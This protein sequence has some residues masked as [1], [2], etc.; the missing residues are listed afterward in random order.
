MQT[1]CQRKTQ[2]GKARILLMILFF[3]G[4]L[5]G[6][7]ADSLSVSSGTVTINT[8]T[9][10]DFITQ[11]GGTLTGAG[12]LGS[13]GLWTWSAG[14]LT[15]V[16]G[17][18]TA[19]AM[20]GLTISGTSTKYLTNRT[21]VNTSGN[22]A[23]WSGGTV[24]LYNTSTVQN[25]GTF[26]VTADLTMSEQSGTATF[27]NQGTFIKSTTT[28]TTS[29][30]GIDFINATNAQLDVQK[31][32]LSITGA[33]TNE[34][35]ISVASGSALT[36]GGSSQH[37][38]GGNI[39]VAG[40]L[41]LSS[42]AGNTISGTYQSSNTTI[43]A[44]TT[45]FNSFGA[46]LG[47]TS[48]TGSSTKVYFNENNV[49]TGNITLNS[50]AEA[51]FTKESGMVT[52]GTLNIYNS[53]KANMINQTVEATQIN[54]QSSGQL[55]TSGTQL[56]NSSMA[57]SVA[58]GIAN[59][60]NAT[61]VT[62]N[63][64]TASSGTLT[65]NNS[66]LNSTT[67]TN[68]GA[69]MTFQSG[70]IVS[71][72]NFS[73]TSGA[74]TFQAGSSLNSTNT[75]L[76]GGTVTLETG[77]SIGSTNFTVSGATVSF[78][79]TGP[80]SLT[81]FTQSSGTVNGS[82]NIEVN[83]VYTWSGGNLYGVD[84]SQTLTAKG[85]MNL[86]TTTKYL[87]NRAIV[88]TA[89]Q[90]ATWNAGTINMYNTS[91]FVN[92]GL[93]EITGN[94]SMTE[95]SGTATFENYGTLTKKTGTSTTT[96][97]SVDFLNAEN[98]TMNIETGAMTISGLLTN[99]GTVNI[100]SGRTLTLSGS[101]QHQI[102][103]TVQGAGI[104]TLSSS[105]GNTISGMY[106]VGTTNI[107]GGSTTS[108]NSAN[109]S[110]GTASI[111]GSNTKVNFNSSNVQTNNMTVNSS[112]EAYFLADQGTVNI[113]GTLLVANSAKTSMTNQ[114]VTANQMDVQSSGQLIAN[115]TQL[116]S[117]SMVFNIAGGIADISNATNVNANTTTAS[118]GTLTVNNST[119][120]SATFTNSG[121]T[122]TFQT[123]A[124][125]N[126]NS[127]SSTGGTTTFQA[128]SF[129]NS[130]SATVS[131]GTTILEAGS[132]IN[133]TNFTVTGNGT[134]NGTAS[135]TGTGTHSLNNLTLEAY[136]TI[137]GSS[138][139]EVNGIYTWSGGYLYGTDGTQTLTAKGGMNLATT[140]KYLYNRT[141]VNT[142]GQTANWSAGTINMYNA[143]KFVNQ[144]LFEIT[145]N[146]SMT[147]QSGTATFENYGTLTKKTGTSTSAFNNV[148]FLNAENATIN[149]ET[150]AMTISGLF[151]NQGTVNLSS[152]RTLTLSGSSLHQIGGTVQGAGIVTLSSSGGNTISGTYNVGATNISGSSTTNF[153]TALV[154]LGTTNITGASTKVN[155]N[156]STVN[157][158]SMTVNTSGEAYFLADQGNVN[159]NGTLLIANSSKVSMTNQTVT[160]NQIDVQSSGQLITSGT[161]LGNS[162]MVFNI[163]GGTANL[164]NATNVTANTT[165]ASSGALTIN[166]S[167]LTSAT[168]TNSGA[169]STFQ[170][171]AVLQGTT[172]SQ[173]SGTTNFQAG[174]SLNSTNATFSG[175]TSTLE[176]GSTINST[177]FT[178]SG[179][180]VS[181]TGT[182]PHNF[183]NLT[184][185]SGTINGSGNIEVNGTW[186]WSGGYVYGVDG[187][188][189]LI[190]KGG[191]SLAT[192][193]K[194]LY[195]RTIIN[196]EGQSANWITGTINMYN[197]SKFVNQGL[198]EI[199]G[200]NSMTEQSG[201]ATFENYGTLTKKTGTGNTTLT[202]VDFLNAENAVVNLEMGTMTISGLVT[203][204]GTINL[205]SGKTLTL[206]G[207]SQHQIGGTVQGA[208]ILTLS[209]SGGNT[210]SGVYNVGTS[211]ISGGSTT[212][213]HTAS[214]SLGTTSI[215]GANTKVN[216]NSSNVQTNNLTV[217]TS[218][219]AY[220]LADQGTVNIN[221]NLLIAN[222]SRLDMA[223]Q[224]VATNQIDVQSSAQ[225]NASGTQIGSA[226]M[227]FNVSG[228]T[229]NL[230]N[231]TTLTANTT[232]ASSGTL[233]VNNSTLNSATFNNSGATS[234]FQ[235][236]AVLNGT[237]FTQ[238]SGAVV[239]ESGSSLN[240]TSVAIN[241][242]TATFHQG[243][244]IGSTNFTVY[245]D[246]TNSTTATFSGAETHTLTNLSLSGSTAT[247][248]GSSN[249]EVNGVYTWSGGYLYGVDGQQA[250]TAKGGM[251]LSGSDKYLYNRTI[252]NAANQTA[253]WSA[254]NINLYNT[255]KFIN[256]GN[257]D[258]MA[259]TTMS[260]Q[261]GTT[262]FEN[263]GTLAKKAGTG[264]TYLSNVDFVNAEN[265]QISVESGYLRIHGS[266]VNQGTIN[267]ASGT[268]FYV[269]GTKMN[270]IAGTMQG[271][272]RA[273]LYSTAGH[274]INGTYNMGS[275]YITNGGITNFN[276]QSV[277]LGTTSITG[278][279]STVNFYSGNV[280][281]A[282]L[283]TNST[284]QVNFLS[285]GGSVNTGLLRTIS[286]SVLNMSNQNVNSTEIRVEGTSQLNTSGTQLGSS[287]TIFSVQGGTANLSSG[288]IAT[289][290][291]TTVSSGTLNVNNSAIHAAT[292][293][294]SGGVSN[295]QENSALNGANFNVTSGTVNFQAGSALNSTT[296]SISG[297][298]TNFQAGSS[299][300]STTTT[301]S[302][303]DVNFEAGSAINANNLVVNGSSGTTVVNGTAAFQAG[304]HT[305][306]N[307]TIQQY[308][309]VNGAGNIAVNNAFVWSGGYLYG[310]DG[311]QT[312]T[313]NAGMELSD[314][315]KY[316]YDRTVVNT[317]GQTATW[318]GG[319]INLYNTSKFINHGDFHL[320]NNN[321]MT[322]QS[323]T[324]TLENYGTLTKTASTGTSTFSNV[325]VLNAANAQIQVQTGTMSISGA[326]TN[327]GNINISSGATLSL[328]GSTVHQLSGTIQG[329]GTFNVSSSAGVNITGTYNMSNTSLTGG[330]TNFMT[331]NASLGIANVSGSSTYV[332]FENAAQANSI[333]VSSGN[334]VNKTSLT[335]T[336][337]QNSGGTS[338]FQTG[339]VMNAPTFT[340]SSGT[341]DFQTGSTLNATTVD[342]NGGTG[343]FTGS[344]IASDNFN[345]TG[346]TTNLTGAALNSTTTTMTAGTTRF[347]SSSI[348]SQDFNMSGG[349][350]YFNGT[351]KQT[352]NNFNFSGGNVYGSGDV[353]V[354][355][356][357]N[358]TAGYVRG[359]TGQEVL[360]LKGATNISTTSAKR[361]YNRTVVN[362]ENQT[363]SWT[364]GTINLYDT[365]TIINK[366]NL[367]STGNTTIYEQTGTAVFHNQG[368]LVKKTATGTTYFT[369]MDV[370]NTGRVE[371]QSG[372]LNFN[373]SVYTQNAGLTVLNGGSITSSNTMV[374][375]GGAI[376]G[377]GTITASVLVGSDARL[378]PGFSPGL[379]DIDGSLTLNAGSIL[380]IEIEN[381]DGTLGISHDFLDIRDD[382]I[383]SSGVVL[384]VSLSQSLAN[385]L[386]A[387]LAQG[388]YRSFKILSAGTDGT[389][390]ISLT[391][392]QLLFVDEN[393][394]WSA[395]V[396]NNKDLY[397]QYNG[398]TYIPVP[399]F[400]AS[401]A[402]FGNVRIGTQATGT[403]TVTNTSDIGID[404]IN[405]SIGSVSANGFSSTP[406]DQSFSN[407]AINSSVSRTYT[408]APTAI[409]NH[410]ATVN[411]NTNIG[412]QVANL[413]G[414]G[415]SPVFSSSIAPNTLIDFGTVEAYSSN[416]YILRI[417]NLTPEDLGNLTNLTL[418]SA[419][420]SGMDAG[421]FSIENFTPGTVLGKNAYLD[422]L[423]RATNPEWRFAYRSGILTLVT[424]E[425]AAFG[426]AGNTYTFYLT[427]YMVPEPCTYIV[428]SLAILVFCIYRKKHCHAKGY[429]NAKIL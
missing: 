305:V 282:A 22:S 295:F 35:N 369:N 42:S 265:A 352:L 299:L 262:T 145:G 53:S 96:L 191:M 258:A 7:Q 202:N 253:T 79:G 224:T 225:F 146:N 372:I 102:G 83:G 397:L 163:A 132:T 378:A 362:D 428:M 41:T 52:L 277:S 21:L 99:Q 421:Y 405:G 154:S 45:N 324:A 400:T 325:D 160:A 18:Q 375:N 184:Q 289:T 329:E 118:S 284:A 60:S 393:Y 387:D 203:N 413:N 147:E 77:S 290:S 223:N 152:G 76:S 271:Q 403:I 80:H 66:T 314:T 219:E 226:S 185:S 346:A 221:G 189:T 319:T 128:G 311:Q 100:S 303:G 235:A 85:G 10:Y 309:I 208:G 103:G 261:S 94:N 424:D 404:P 81:N 374:I 90:T 121:A 427:A 109:V 310:V 267:V 172:F 386:N 294:S 209:S 13:T 414:T 183:A 279:N 20:G 275:T 363:M 47:T 288:T 88:N 264:Y 307:L 69:T 113:N 376:A 3:F 16:D 365:T 93:F 331:N 406:G 124:V 43:S 345:L 166:N 276:S 356:T 257:F 234:T 215:T 61:T 255:N 84:G 237:S 129:L 67:F 283:T 278:T 108:F 322:E 238:S 348:A 274:N 312:L 150:G 78:A 338:T 392:S 241:R 5:E 366:G 25:Q 220:F 188:Q 316:M 91:K 140:T 281:T 422:L 287:S 134:L 11:T 194:Y 173:T 232:T 197:T 51:N 395:Y 390:S 315:T 426:M 254:G 101:S 135:F 44:G 407:L 71:G 286:S 49:Q 330:T 117:A 398:P 205:S 297:G 384:N 115:G 222:S 15:G 301:I 141:I 23:T 149:I 62:A 136:G 30:S 239:F 344:T 4:L 1:F 419:T 425:N 32:T 151:T 273:Y 230:T 248:N 370:I 396:L 383:F 70:A 291:T 162:S 327:E 371:V 27:Q 353:D 423:L 24:Y 293:T 200:N 164:S 229:A 364:A 402:S 175:G 39:N 256:Y 156:G 416:E 382:A 127:F 92:Q 95:Q 65:L 321:S 337:F 206:S 122:S 192:T 37:Q 250:L 415:V 56:G 123:G 137:N 332:N 243:I 213:F 161:Q 218:G 379:L 107:S 186:T 212:N 251:D 420:L 19:T 6:L 131:G 247:I 195:N 231:G 58:G 33:V 313:A 361:L 82:G 48:I 111:T 193:T 410:S 227:I 373:N 268:Y 64:T 401:N 285:N 342:L 153:N 244:T 116:G 178:V 339:S 357:W 359:N 333:T 360:T 272:G 89:G 12:N 73:Q 228:G 377:S 133:S 412:N 187:T 341:V 105:G 260:L 50:S 2:I 296:A 351:D 304:S 249:L 97:N 269:S 242:G 417:Q 349:A 9:T 104:V 216:F 207:S 114:S 74:T 28:G 236:G 270:E 119:I 389:G 158:D 326:L 300:N 167:T 350:L 110:L 246:G 196:A 429:K 139:L 14:Y 120:N 298:T 59:L 54:V 180:T 320:T 72:D 367:E 31:G 98:A 411:I 26:S 125:L 340:M 75:T 55:N 355:G 182:G 214:V 263:Y 385:T 8:D 176:T 157:T 199:T 252:I 240:S 143:S 368:T 159:I 179:A 68:S 38:L 318:S 358:W 217:N 112:G 399:S 388:I 142:E 169:T 63:T 130:T 306:N 198:F 87:Y 36:L 181:L 170:A 210:I 408:Y 29:L 155:F 259:D 34:G 40:T 334:L 266:L 106:N 233:I 394:L 380:D 177:N 280:Q 190:A 335:A 138:N 418:L 86:S 126:G 391:P 174:S 328:S 201:T 302:K 46:S 165:T 57:F 148:D 317:T 144:G 323:G 168:F 17:Q 381:L 343:N 292:F 336:T 354:N 204:Q 211:N 308:G 409:G 347:T 245:G 171:G